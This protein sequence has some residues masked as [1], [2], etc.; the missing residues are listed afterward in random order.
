MWCQDPG[1][2]RNSGV[3]ERPLCPGVT[4]PTVGLPDHSRSTTEASRAYCDLV[5]LGL[6][7]GVW[8]LCL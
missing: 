2:G 1:V 4:V 7:V 5:R 6:A 8:V 3:Y